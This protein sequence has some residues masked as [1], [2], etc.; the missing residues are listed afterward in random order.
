VLL[1]VAGL[2]LRSLDASLSANVG[3]RMDG[4]ATVSADT[5]MLGYAEDR[6]NQFWKDALE[7]I[8][9]LPGVES[10]ALASPR[11]PFDI[12]YNQ[13]S[14]RIDGKTY[15]AEERGDVLA[16]VAVS[17]EY[18][19]TLDIPIVEGRGFTAADREGAP[20]VAIVN[21]AMARKYWPNQ[22]AVGRTFTLTF[23]KSQYQVIGVSAD[24]R[25][26]NVY[27]AP[28]PYLHFAALQGP[29]RYNHLVA[30]TRG[31]ATQVLAA[32]RREL[33]AMDPGIV[34]VNSTTMTSSLESS[35]LP[36]RVGT[37]LA[38]AFGGLG[39]LLAAIGLYG[40]IAFSVARRTREIGVRM[41]VG[42][43][44][45]TV[46]SMVM[47]QGLGLT[48]IGGVVGLVLAAIAANA[49]RGALYGIS[50]FDPLAWLVALGVLVAA[51]ALANFI[52]AR[53]AM[54]INPVTALRTE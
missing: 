4:L 21:Q 44:A 22:S 51:A 9:A 42:A 24:H 47:R 7:R 29:L 38:G 48:A 18:F 12:N 17:P 54:Q 40:V 28:T 1:V 34:F 39:T 19:A 53:R 52:P 16:N 50:A 37:A 8:K 5:R 43:N 14:I 49:M 41:A 33:L 31:N 13:T 25:V 15:G 46:L 36:A 32:M 3:F 27:E 35:L 6:A 2:M 30:R 26:H 11:L 23:G 20:L 45:G 10:A